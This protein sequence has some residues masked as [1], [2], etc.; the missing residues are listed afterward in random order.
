M[1]TQGRS[2]AEKMYLS[3]VFR[4]GLDEE[5]TLNGHLMRGQLCEERPEEVLRTGHAKVLR[6]EPS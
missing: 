4:E 1:V 2:V 6:Q 5:L 3:R